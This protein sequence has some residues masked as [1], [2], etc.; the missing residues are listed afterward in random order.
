MDDEYVP[1]PSEVVRFHFGGCMEKLDLFLL[2]FLPLGLGLIFIYDGFFL[3]SE[4]WERVLAIFTG[5]AGIAGM[6]TFEYFVYKGLRKRFLYAKEVEAGEALEEAIARGEVI[7]HVI[8]RKVIASRP[9]EGPVEASEPQAENGSD[10]NCDSVT[11]ADS[12]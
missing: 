7:S 6:Y 10:A 11:P 4:L 3:E 1:K 12:Q 2:L 8:D 5:I 9:T